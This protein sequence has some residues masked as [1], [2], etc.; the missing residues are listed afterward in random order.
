MKLFANGF[1]RKLAEW[2][3]LIFSD[4]LVVIDLRG[5]KE[6][7][8]MQCQGHLGNIW[9]DSNNIISQLTGAKVSWKNQA[10][11]QAATEIVQCT[12]NCTFKRFFLH[13]PVQYINTITKAIFTQHNLIYQYNT[14]AEL[15]FRVPLWFSSDLPRL[16]PWHAHPRAEGHRRGRGVRRGRVGILLRGR[17]RGGAQQVRRGSLLGVRS[18]SSFLYVL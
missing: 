10:F 7:R 9:M 5:R 17:R 15:P 14:Q 12:V 11:S 1:V 2:W 4:L 8:S 3:D 16:P 18:I 13:E 6:A